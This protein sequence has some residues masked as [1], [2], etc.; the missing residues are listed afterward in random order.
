MKDI[1]WLDISVDDYFFCQAVESQEHLMRNRVRD[2]PDPLFCT[3]L[4]RE[5]QIS[6]LAAYEYLHLR[7]ILPSRSNIV[8]DMDKKETGTRVHTWLIRERISTSLFNAECN[9]F[10]HPLSLDNSCGRCRTFTV[11]SLPVSTSMVSFTVLNCPD[12]SSPCFKCLISAY[13]GLVC[14]FASPSQR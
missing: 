10:L 8:D 9:D 12:P 5:L 4:D 11:M 13:Q 14:V 2:V 3:V 1:L 6:A 7:S